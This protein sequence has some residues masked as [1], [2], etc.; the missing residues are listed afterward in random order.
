[1]EVTAK[2]RYYRQSPRK[3]R[4]VANLI[5]G[6]DAKPAVAQLQFLNKT[7]AR[8]IEKLLNSAIANAT[9]NFS[10]NSDNLYIKSIMVDGGPTLKRW[11]ARAFGRAAAIR[12]HTSHVTVILNEKNP[13]EQIIKS[14]KTEPAVNEIKAPIDG[15]VKNKETATDE[16]TDS[17]TSETSK[18]KRRTPWS[19]KSLKKGF[20]PK[21]FQRKA[22]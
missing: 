14:V 15:A 3:V 22:G 21:I 17:K 18:T 19:G 13:T 7:A 4:L 1:M 9:H 11:R 10:L 12:K 2:L 20:M 5:R 16:K 6:L 8:A